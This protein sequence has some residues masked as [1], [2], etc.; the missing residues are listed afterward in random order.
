MLR[1]L[2]LVAFVLVLLSS[3]VLAED[4]TITWLYPGGEQPVDRAVIE[5]HLERWEALHPEIKVDVIDV[6]WSLAHDRIVSMIMA[7]DLPDMIHIGSRWLSEFTDMGIVLPLE[8][9]FAEKRSL[10]YPGLIQTVEVEGVLHALPRAYSTQALHY[11][12]DLIEQPPTTWEELIEVSQKLQ[13]E[14]PDIYGFAFAGSDHVSTLSQYFTVLFTYGGSLTD[15]AGRLTFN[16]QEAVDA[17]SLLVRL[18]EEKLVPNPLEYH[19]EELP[20]L[21]GAG[22]IAMFISGPWGGPSTG[23]EPDN[24]RIPYQSALIP[25]GP[26]GVATEVVSDSTI[27]TPSTE[28]LDEVLLFLDFITS[29]E[30]QVHRDKAGA[31]PQGP[32]IADL[33]EFRGDPYF[34]TFIEMGDYGVPQ[35]KP[36]LWEP[37]QDVIVEMVQSALLGILTPE[38]AVAKASERM[39]AEGIVLPAK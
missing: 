12:T 17:L 29:V 2:L 33:P 6:P 22:R 4:V 37:L 9:Y 10:Y 24:D 13:E 3:S 39:V 18:Y 27:V 34:E 7:D 1:R 36:G 5:G 14:N 19:R 16:S 15:D 23:L 25:A 20:E 26:A 31:L 38:E 11:R 32:E 35:P 28:H 30:E 8:E 21:F